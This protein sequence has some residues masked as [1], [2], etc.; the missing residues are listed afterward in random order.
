MNWNF[1]N[2]CINKLTIMSLHFFSL[3]L[4]IRSVKEIR[5]LKVFFLT[6]K[7]T[8]RGHIPLTPKA[9]RTYSR[10]SLRVPCIIFLGFNA[11]QKF[12]DQPCCGTV[13]LFHIK[14]SW[15]ICMY[16][17]GVRRTLLIWLDLLQGRDRDNW[18]AFGHVC[19]S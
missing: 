10:L 13:H 4:P 3:F 9:T 8:N 1:L 16:G 6:C 2:A 19:L 15:I 17:R 5:K 12:S 14:F 18:W 7:E 11:C